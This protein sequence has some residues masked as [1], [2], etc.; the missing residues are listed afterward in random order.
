VSAAGTPCTAHRR[1]AVA[2]LLLLCLTLSV[3]LH[4][5]SAIF[6]IDCRHV[7]AITRGLLQLCCG[8]WFG[9]M[10][11]VLFGR[12]ALRMRRLVPTGR[13]PIP[14]P[15]VSNALNMEAIQ[16]VPKLPRLCC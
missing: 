2:G 14:K 11:T 1:G 16:Q 7:T 13:A 3:S 15:G 4:L 10:R 6:P 12:T 8:R 9:L 5:P